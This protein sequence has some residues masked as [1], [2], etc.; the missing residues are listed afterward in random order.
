MQHLLLLKE[1]IFKDIMTKLRK[2]P[3]LLYFVS[4]VKNN[5]DEGFFFHSNAVKSSNVHLLFT[6]S[7]V[8]ETLLDVYFVP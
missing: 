1:P 3:E 2:C 4:L 5:G 7:L 6:H 8:R